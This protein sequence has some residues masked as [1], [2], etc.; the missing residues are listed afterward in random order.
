MAVEQSQAAGRLQSQW[1]RVGPLMLH[2]KTGV[3]P[4]PAG[5]LPLVCVHGLL[6][7]GRYMLAAAVRLAPAHPVY[8]LDLPG[9]GRS[10]KPPAAWPGYTLSELSRVLHD[11]LDA[12]GLA[13]VGL[14]A[15]SFGCQ[16]A[17]AFARR[18]P[19]R[20]ACLVLVGPTVDARRRSLGPQAARLALDA[21]RE[22]LRRYVRILVPDLVEIGV[23]RAVRLAGVAL[24]DRIEERLPAVGVP[25][26]V[27]RGGRDPLVPQEWAEAVVALL[28][29]GHL[30]TIPGSGHVVHFAAPDAFVDA[31]R[32]FLQ[33]ISE[34]S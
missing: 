4:A 32:P 27:I 30:V 31:V 34:R 23:P 10:S 5:R 6:V 19:G 18:Y 20:A 24:R 14:I 16:I 2:C 8:A 12:R 22:P 15:N 21:P 11:W 13:R 25:T 26:L 7:S 29:Q 1:T 17:T 33:R 3:D 28:P 9:Y